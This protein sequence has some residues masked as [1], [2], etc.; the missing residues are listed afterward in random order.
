[1]DALAGARAGSG[2]AALAGAGAGSGVAALA[3]VTAAG[4]GET[5]AAGDVTAAPA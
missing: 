5:D 4:A 3:G 1:L 2:V